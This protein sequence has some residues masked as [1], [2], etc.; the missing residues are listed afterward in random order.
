MK[1]LAFK[2]LVVLF[3][4]E[5]TCFMDSFEEVLVIGIALVVFYIN[6]KMAVQ[7]LNVLIQIVVVG[8]V[9]TSDVVILDIFV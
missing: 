4:L 9:V 6:V 7:V 1:E 5:L 2:N 8:N 3:E